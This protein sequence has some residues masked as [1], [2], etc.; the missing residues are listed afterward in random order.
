[1]RTVLRDKSRAPMPQGI[2]SQPASKLDYCK[3][4]PTAPQ[5]LACF[6]S[7]LPDLEKLERNLPLLRICVCAQIR[8]AGARRRRPGRHAVQSG[9]APAQLGR[10]RQLAGFFR[11]LLEADLRRRHQGRAVRSRGPDVVQ[12]TVVAVAKQMRDGGYDRTKSSF[13][14][15]LCLITRRRI[16]DHF[17]KRTDPSC[18]RR[19][20]LATTPAARTPSPACPTRPASNSTPCGRKNGRRTCSTPPS[21]A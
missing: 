3:P 14:N 1:M 16:I 10:P 20:E 2:S 12:E 19:R 6:K 21:S 11:H 8:C 18:A 13:K 9:E 4:C 5:R 15:W 7:S 17:R